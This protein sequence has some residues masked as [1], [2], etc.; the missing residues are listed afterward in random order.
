ML[1]PMALLAGL[2]VLG[3]FVVACGGD[4]TPTPQ[5]TP[6]PVDVGAITTAISALE[7][8][9]QARIQEALEAAPAAEPALS[10]SELRRLVQTAVAAAVPETA[11]P[12]DI[13]ALIGKAVAASVTPGLTASEVQALVT[14]AVSEA[15]ATGPSP[16]TA[17]GVQAIVEQ[18]VAAIPTATPQPTPTPQPAPVDPRRGGII[19]FSALVPTIHFDT[20][21][22][23][24]VISMYTTQV[25]NLLIE[26]NPE[27]DDPLELRG[28][29]AKSWALSQDGTS[30]TFSL[31]EN[32]LWHD[33]VP[34]TAEDIKFTLDLFVTPGEAETRA[35]TGQFI[36]PFYKGSTVMDDHT[37]RVD[38]NFPNALFLQYISTNLMEMLPK[39][40]FEG[41]DGEFRSAE[42]NL[43]GSGP[44]I[45]S[46]NERGV[47]TEFTR[48]PNY[49]KEGR[50]FLDGLKYFVIQQASAVIGAHKTGQ[51]LMSH[52][53]ATGL[54]NVEA[55]KLGEDETGKLTVHWGGPMSQI[56]VFLNQT[57]GSPFADI[58]VRQ[59]V[60]LAIHRQPIIDIVDAG[61]GTLGYP[62]PPG[63]WFA[64]PESEVAQLPGFRE[65][66]GEKHPDDLAE[67]KR[68]MAD[69]GFANGFETDYIAKF[70]F[71]EDQFALIVADQL[72]RFLN[73]TGSVNVLEGVALDT[74]VRAG[75]F[76]VNPQSLGL[77]VLDPEDMY[78]RIWETGTPNNYGP[79]SIA[80]IDELGQIQRSTISQDERAAA[81]AETAQIILDEL[82]AI[83]LFWAERPMVV[84]NKIQNFHMP[85][86]FYS[87][88]FKSEHLWCDP[89]C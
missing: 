4:D 89:A 14:R 85:Q 39:H 26:H 7:Q 2:A 66:N 32:A 18:A 24:G 86:V 17:Q 57:E 20:V 74:R 88:G 56:V 5:P 54:S 78:N 59:A 41:K 12:E 84:H 8:S 47:S 13:E 52:H 6:T 36:K 75:D 79:W 44:F 55:L 43:L 53:V 11:S 63:F 60:N 82:P 9:I 15:A 71:A 64:I 38:M 25:Y 30:Y 58:R 45:L 10:E 76:K 48:N 42:E 46:N 22:G 69:A 72:N 33:G 1:K 61:R 31:H 21:E 51:V 34:V 80:R 40:Q 27:G 68:L 77:V 67:A 19:T 16:L 70:L 29:L 35:W 87:Y 28:D 83:G 65:L 50:P 73:I 62:F 3:L 23:D 37:I 81:V 49:F